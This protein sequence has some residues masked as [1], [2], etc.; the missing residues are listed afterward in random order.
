D[1]RPR[2]RCSASFVFVVGLEVHGYVLFAMAHADAYLRAL[3]Y[4][5]RHLHVAVVQVFV[6]DPLAAAALREAFFGGVDDPGG[7]L[8]VRDGFTVLLHADFQDGFL[9]RN[10]LANVRGRD[11]VAILFDGSELLRFAL[12]VVA[13]AVVA[14]A[15]LVRR[16]VAA[17]PGV[18]GAAA[19]GRQSQA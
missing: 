16:G 15:G 12:V 8:R 13:V 7:N 17:A 9:A 14:A 18:V 1:G 2:S 4:V 10:H 19:A 5:G 11:L 3:G 6:G